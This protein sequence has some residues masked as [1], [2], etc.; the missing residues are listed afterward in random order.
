MDLL[1]TRFAPRVGTVKLARKLPDLKANS[2]LLDTTAPMVRNIN[3]L[4]AS[5]KTGSEWT[6]A[7]LAPQVTSV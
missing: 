1:S 7:H 4:L 3:A 2:A 5:T 6:V